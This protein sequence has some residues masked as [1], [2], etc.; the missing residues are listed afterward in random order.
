MKK[1]KTDAKLLPEYSDDSD[2]DDE[3]VND[4]FS[5]NKSV[6][7]PPVEDIPLDIDKKNIE[8]EKV[9]IPSNQKLP[10]KIQSYFKQ[11]VENHVELQP[12][13][14]EGSTGMEYGRDEASSSA[15]SNHEAPHSANNGDIQLDDEAVSTKIY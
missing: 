15:H 1:T 2:N 12:D 9:T 14:S 4:F 11:D 13:Y 5:M 3:I 10:P 7:L 6:E 8:P